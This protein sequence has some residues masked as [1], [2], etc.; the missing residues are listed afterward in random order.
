MNYCSVNLLSPFEVGLNLA[1]GLVTSCCSC[2]TAWWRPACCWLGR[3]SMSIGDPNKSHFGWSLYKQ[4]L[5]SPFY[6]CCNISLLTKIIIAV[7]EALKVQ[8]NAELLINC[9][10]RDKS[11][12]Q[13]VTT[14]FQH[15]FDNPLFTKPI[16]EKNSIPDGDVAATVRS[17]NQKVATKIGIW[18][19]VIP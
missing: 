11:N 12:D 6:L 19:K 17:N 7:G 10:S 16:W 4:K 2:Q 15:L 3:G 13:N 5:L 14:K 8:C 1:L 9:F 18:R